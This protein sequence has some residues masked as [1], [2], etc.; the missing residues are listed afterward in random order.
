[1]QSNGDLIWAMACTQLL[2]M[3]QANSPE[4]VFE[5]HEPRVG[6]EA[7]PLL[8]FDELGPLEVELLMSG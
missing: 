7:L 2:G 4:K 5:S 6:D 3:E 8:E 1:M